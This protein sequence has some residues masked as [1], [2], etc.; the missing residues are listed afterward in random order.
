[1]LF[2]QSESKPSLSSSLQLDRMQITCTLFQTFNHTSTSLL[3]FYRLYALFDAQ[4]TIIVTE[5][6]FVSE[7]KCHC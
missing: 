3:N 6:E 7:V 1:M 5:M 2:L 4:S